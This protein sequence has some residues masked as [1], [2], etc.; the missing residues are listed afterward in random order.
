MEFLKGWFKDTLPDAPI[1]TLS[2]IRLDGDMYSSTIEALSAL[3][4]RLAPGGFV[5]VD[6][7]ALKGARE[8]VDRYRADEGIEDPIEEIDWTGVFWR[9]SRAG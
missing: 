6:D 2:V 7:Y 5:I 9:R 3:Y 1:Q 4:P 8:A